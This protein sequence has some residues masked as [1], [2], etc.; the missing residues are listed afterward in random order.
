MDT[1]C[2]HTQQTGEPVPWPLDQH[3]D[4]PSRVQA[5]KPKSR[6]VQSLRE[7]GGT[8]GKVT[9]ERGREGACLGF[10]LPLDKA[11]EFVGFRAGLM[12]FRA[13]TLIRH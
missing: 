8:K 3:L 7:V 12:G 1:R 13:Q 4:T 6:K 5:G 11:A 10:E 2:P 9:F